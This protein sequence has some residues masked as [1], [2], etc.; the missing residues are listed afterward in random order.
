VARGTGENSFLPAEFRRGDDLAVPCDLV[1]ENR[2]I[3][4]AGMDQFFP[5]NPD[6]GV[7]AARWRG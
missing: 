3:P 6:I 2:A 5:D 4:S 7:Q 1:G